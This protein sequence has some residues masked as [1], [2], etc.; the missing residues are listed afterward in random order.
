VRRNFSSLQFGTPSETLSGHTFKELP[1]SLGLSCAYFF[2]GGSETMSD[3]AYGA[4]SAKTA[5]GLDTNVAHWQLHDQVLETTLVRQP[6]VPADPLRRAWAVLAQRLESLSPFWTVFALTLTETVGA[7]ILA[8]PIA[9]AGVG[10]LPGVAILIVLGLVNT[11]TIAAMA[12]A[13]ARSG[14][15]HHDNAFIGRV[16]S[17]YLGRAASLVISLGLIVECV[18]TLWPY[19]IGFSTTLADATRIPAP[20]WG[21]LLFLGGLWLLRRETLDATVA[22]ALVI[23]VVN[24][25]L[26]LALSLLALAHL[27]PAHL[28]YA[29]VPLLGGRP[30]D[31]SILQ[32]IFG[33]VLLAYFGHLSVNNCARSVLRRD[34]SARSLVQGAVAAQVVAMALYCLWTLAVNG[35]IAPQALAGQPGTA[36]APLAAEIG[37]IV[38]VLGAVF[39]VLGMGMGTVHSSWPLFNLVRERLP[40]DSRR[41]L[42]E[43]AR[44]FLSAVPVLIVFLLA[45]WTLLIGKGTFAAPLGFL[46]VIVISLLGGMFPVLLLFASRCKGKVVSCVWGRV[47]GRPALTIGVYLLYLVGLFLHGLVIWENPVQRVAALAVGVATLGLTAALLRRGTFA[48]PKPDLP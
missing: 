19:Y 32:L 11:L 15:V 9:L 1:K 44:F 26:I 27:K 3:V 38:H 8:L 29:N 23:G 35:A 48:R 45:E 13:V 6:S 22:S 7:G 4:L 14:D 18:L 37:P 21:A 47:L 43:R 16:V 20:V 31:A 30:F 12:Q 46:G 17:G 28:L 5:L 33:V 10:P 34:P 41:L 42:G 2:D 40:A 39:V 24:I 36:L 25:A